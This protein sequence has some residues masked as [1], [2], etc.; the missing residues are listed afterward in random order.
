MFGGDRW[1]VYVIIGIAVFF[2]IR[3]VL[4]WYWKANRMVQLL[5]QIEENTR[6]PNPDDTAANK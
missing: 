2:A 6:K 4:T 5:E 3:E 1:I